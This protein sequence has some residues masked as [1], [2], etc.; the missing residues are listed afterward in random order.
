MQN[1][2]SALIRYTFFFI[3]RKCFLVT[4][5]QYT[6]VI[7]FEVKTPSSESLIMKFLLRN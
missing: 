7:N 5:I 2:K 4:V 6:G 1:N 3:A